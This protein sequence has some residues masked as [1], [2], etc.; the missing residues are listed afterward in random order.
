MTTLAESVGRGDV[1]KLLEES[2]SRMGMSS[3]S[4]D[5]E[6]ESTVEEAVIQFEED[7]EKAEESAES[8]SE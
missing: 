4:N 2:R 7:E 8:V 6:D 3:D 1:K 5:S